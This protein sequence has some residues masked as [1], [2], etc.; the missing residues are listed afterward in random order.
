MQHGKNDDGG[1]L[2]RMF[3]V[4]WHTH[5]RTQLRLRWPRNLARCRWAVLC[6][7]SLPT[8]LGKLVLHVIEMSW[9]WL[10][11]RLPQPFCEQSSSAF[12]LPSQSTFS[13]HIGPVPAPNVLPIASP[14][15]LCQYRN[16]SPTPKQTQTAQPKHRWYFYRVGQ[17]KWGQLHFWW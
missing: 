9:S 16:L 14:D 11:C 2:A 8:V 1:A 12:S 17:L 6:H 5:T 4:L 13:N 10:Q 15:R 7:F 3:V